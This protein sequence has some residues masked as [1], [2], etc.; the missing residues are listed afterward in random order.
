[1]VA[2]LLNDAR[3]DAQHLREAVGPV[4]W[5]RRGEMHDFV[6]S[7]EVACGF[8]GPLLG[9]TGLREPWTLMF[10]FDSVRQSVVVVV[11]A[12]G[13]VPVGICASDVL[14]FEGPAVTRDEAVRDRVRPSS[15]SFTVDVPKLCVELL[16]LGASG[17]EHLGRIGD[18]S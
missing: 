1:M 9:L 2:G 10:S 3:D 8:L 4:V 11:V 6:F 13:E 17:D 7:S 16:P 12:T 18:F 5:P 14:D 15:L